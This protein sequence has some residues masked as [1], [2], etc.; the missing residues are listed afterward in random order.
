MLGRGRLGA[1]ELAREPAADARVAA[2]DRIGDLRCERRLEQHRLAMKELHA[3]RAARHEHRG[4]GRPCAQLCERGRFVEFGEEAAQ[5]FVG[6]LDPVRERGQ[7]AQRVAIR[8]R[9]HRR[10][11]VRVERDALAGR[12]S[13]LH[14]V[15]QTRRQ[16]FAHDA[17]RADVH[18]LRGIE[19]AGR[20]VGRIEREIG[21]VLADEEIVGRLLRYDHREQRR[22][23]D[24][25]DKAQ[26]EARFG[27]LAHQLVAEQV[28]AD[29]A[30]KGGR[31]AEPRAHAR[32]VPARTAGHAVP[33]VR[34]VADEIGQRFAEYDQAGKR[35]RHVETLCAAAPGR[36]VPRRKRTG[37]AHRRCR[38]S[39]RVH[40]RRGARSRALSAA[41]SSPCSSSRCRA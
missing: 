33:A 38:A 19:R 2:A 37:G 30:G 25:A 15:E 7:P 23:I 11:I 12:A 1:R 36:A 32:D 31:H 34:V 40:R 21:A 22:T 14:D 29:R 9:G 5:I 27:A 24:L 26:I 39:S 6:H 16:R 20:Q 41:C 18:D 10:A 35:R 8:R 28:A 3:R 4:I 17:E 13:D